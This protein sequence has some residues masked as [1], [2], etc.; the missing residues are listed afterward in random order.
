MGFGTI[1]RASCVMGMRT[2]VKGTRLG[3]GEEFRFDALQCDDAQ[4]LARYSGRK[5]C[6]LGKIREENG[7]VDSTDGGEYSILQFD[8]MRRFKAVR[9]VKRVSAISA[10]CGAF[11][12]TKLVEPLDVMK[13]VLISRQEC[14]DAAATRLVTTEDGRQLKAGVGTVVS[15]KYIEAGSVTLSDDNAA[16]EGGETK[17]GGKRHVGMIKLVTVQLEIS[18]VEVTEQGGMLS[19]RGER[20]PRV[21]NLNLEGCELD[22]LTLTIDLNKV[23]LCQYTEIRR[24][25][26]RAFVLEGRKMVRNDAHKLLFQIGPPAS[27]PSNCLVQGELRK[28]NFQRLFLFRGAPLG[29]APGAAFN[30][31]QVDLELEV[32]LTDSYL[33]Y[34]ALAALRESESAWQS[35]LCAVSANQLNHDHVVLHGDHLLRMKGEIVHEFKCAWVEVTARAGFRA[36]GGRCLDHLP[37]FTAGQE[38]KYLAPLTRIL[39]PRSAVTVLNCSANFPVAIEDV[40]GRMIAANPSVGL[41][42]VALSEYHSMDVHGR[43]HTELFEVRSLLYT[44]EEIHD[45]EQLVL[46]PS[47]DRAVTKQFSSYYCQASGECAPSRDPQDFK[48]MRLMQ[49]PE[50]VFTGWWDDMVAWALWWGSV[51]GCCECVLTMVS[52]L[53]KLGTVLCHVGRTDMDKSTL[54]KFVFMPGQELVNLFPGRRA[55]TMGRARRPRPALNAAPPEEEE[56]KHFGWE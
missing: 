40:K 37:V 14:S 33:E 35:E 28:T 38:M 55:D 31:A 49:D 10:V 48:W 4:A 5:F 47:S 45:Y 56:M 17:M 6:E 12:H 27:W 30:P 54:V 42:E 8:E 32:R 23:N 13:P 34:W 46:G 9:C 22:D 52:F 19:V 15:Y 29:G 1:W 25:A 26:F 16:C 3:A 36:E 2:V 41:V 11:S 7:L 21:C 20:L 18:E 43:N 44:P 50:A 24:A 51:W 39:E 53:A